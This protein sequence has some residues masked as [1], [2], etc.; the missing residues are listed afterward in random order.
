MKPFR[1][2]EPQVLDPEKSIKYVQIERVSKF[3]KQEVARASVS[4]QV[5]NVYQQAGFMDF[6]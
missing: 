1:K 3:T 4:Y 2:Q 6:F 5:S